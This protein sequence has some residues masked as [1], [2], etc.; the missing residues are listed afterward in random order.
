[1][2]ENHHSSG[3]RATTPYIQTNLGYPHPT[4]TPTTPRRTKYR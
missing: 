4:P 1:M 2:Q 3:E